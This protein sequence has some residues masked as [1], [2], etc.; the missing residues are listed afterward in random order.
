MANTK[1]VDPE[2]QLDEFDLELAQYEDQQY[3]RSF[4]SQRST[5]EPDYD[6]NQDD[7]PYGMNNDD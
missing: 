4:I 3:V 5:V 2:D 6:Y 1:L 7:Y